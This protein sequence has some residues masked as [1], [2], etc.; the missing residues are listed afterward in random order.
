M[1]IVTQTDALGER[2]GDER[3]VEIICQ[4]GFTGIDYSMFDMD[5]DGRPLNRSDYADHIARVKET[6]DRFGVPFVQSHAPFPSAKKNNE[7]YNKQIMLYIER[8]FDVSYRLGVKTMVVHPISFTDEGTDFELNFNFYQRLVPY[9]KQTGVKVAL[10]NMW[11]RK[12]HRYSPTACGT[13]ETFKQMMDMLDPNL[14]VACLDIGHCGMVGETPQNMVRML[15][16]RHL[17]AL[18]IHDND[19][20][21]DAHIFPFNGT[22]DWDEVTKALADIDYDGNLTF[23]A[24]N[25]LKRCPDFFLP[26]ATK[27]LFEIGKALEQMINSHKM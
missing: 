15:G 11:G 10:E 13:G 4:S 7:E 1:K 22:V 12:E 26:T 5:E 23:E 16:H 27:Y 14:F 25:T 20:L 2:L 21:R 24:D 6:A 18:H 3:A 8:A 17:H 9:I 19:K